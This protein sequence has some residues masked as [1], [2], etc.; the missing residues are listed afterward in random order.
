MNEPIRKINDL[1]IDLLASLIT[2]E[3]IRET[4]GD[5]AVTAVYDCIRDDYQYDAL[6]G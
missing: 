6:G 1:A 2:A 4:Y 5:D 3:E